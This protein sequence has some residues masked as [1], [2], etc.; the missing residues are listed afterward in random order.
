MKTAI[1]M[2]KFKA[3]TPRSEGLRQPLHKSLT[4]T[5]ADECFLD[6]RRKVRFRIEDRNVHI[7]AAAWQFQS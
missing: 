5:A 4:N 1:V 2:L 3:S 7:Q 6:R